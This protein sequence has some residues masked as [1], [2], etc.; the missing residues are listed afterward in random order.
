MKP[1]ICLRTETT[2][3]PWLFPCQWRSREQR[4]CSSCLA[5]GPHSNIRLI[6]PD[7]T[8]NGE[9]VL[10]QLKLEEQLPKLNSFLQENN[11][12]STL[13]FFE[14]SPQALEAV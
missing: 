11:I 6:S 8:N 9:A 7:G 10:E 2:N 3:H 4:G 12:D 14:P 13:S 5:T 1:V